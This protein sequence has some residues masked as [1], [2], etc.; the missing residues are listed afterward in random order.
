MP[1]LHRIVASRR[2]LMLGTAGALLALA[3]ACSPGPMPVSQ[4]PRDP[5]NPSA[6][7]GVTTVASATPAYGMPAESGSG[8]DHSGH[9]HSGH[10]HSG[11]S[12]G[13]H[14]TK[15][16][17]TG[18]E[19]HGAGTAAPAGGAGQGVVYECPM[20]PEVTSNTPGGVCPKCNMKL[21]PK[22]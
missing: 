14:E 4:S 6:S 16:A 5:S 18:H 17:N 13:G 7:E 10:D 20:H 22:K 1:N 11:H 21:V 15:G 12:H 2:T 3:S 8:H 19:G 9:D